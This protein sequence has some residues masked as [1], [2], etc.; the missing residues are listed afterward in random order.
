M[1]LLGARS[2]RNRF[3]LGPLA[4]LMIRR[5]R[6]SDRKYGRSKFQVAS[7]DFKERLRG[8]ITR[9][10]YVFDGTDVEAEGSM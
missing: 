6:W 7:D 2:M 9:K 3:R 8:R 4:P 10:D 5:T 1:A